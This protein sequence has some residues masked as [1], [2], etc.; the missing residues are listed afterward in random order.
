M[1]AAATTPEPERHDLESVLRVM[2]SSDATSDRFAIAVA[3]LAD[4]SRTSA[5]TRKALEGHDVIKR[6]MDALAVP[7]LLKAPEHQ[8]TAIAILR[9][10]GNACYGA[11]DDGDDG[12]DSRVASSIV[13]YG[14]EW[15]QYLPCT[16][17]QLNGRDATVSIMAVRVLNNISTL[18]SAVPTQMALNNLDTWLIDILTSSIL[19]DDVVTSAMNLLASI[20]AL[21][22]R[23]P[24][25]PATLSKERLSLLL[26]LAEKY[27]C[28]PIHGVMSSERLA[29]VSTSVCNYLSGGEGQ[30]KQIVDFGLQG[31]LWDLFVLVD[32]LSQAPGDVKDAQS[33]SGEIL[34]RNLFQGDGRLWDASMEFLKPDPKF[35]SVSEPV[36]EAED[37]RFTQAQLLS[38]VWLL[39][40]LAD[41]AA[42]AP[43]GLKDPLVED[44][45]QLLAQPPITET[46]SISA[47]KLSPYR[48]TA[49]CQILSNVLNHDVWRS[50]AP[51]VQHDL[52]HTYMIADLLETDHDEYLHA[53]SYLLCQLARPSAE[54]RQQLAL[55]PGMFGVCGR[56]ARHHNP[57]LREDAARLITAL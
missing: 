16:K 23:E 46:E 14:F 1:A 5:D 32:R 27:A 45:V 28:N 49:A 12:D 21:G 35:L 44:I 20:Y 57:A 15:V 43:K 36:V 18:S 24:P 52:I 13:E 40:D 26:S 19:L 10:L 25:T 39:S 22:V 50:A 38:Y 9:C 33:K 56:L 7:I 51:L 17:T 31:K 41:D 54:V 8:T 37:Q 2:H 48:L 53:G 6:L 11:G 4:L 47:R 3:T 34:R 29:A 30:K 55:T 42:F